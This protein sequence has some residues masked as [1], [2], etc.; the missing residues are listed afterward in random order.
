M[1]LVVGPKILPPS[2]NVLAN[3]NALTAIC[4]NETSSTHI[5][6]KNIINIILVAEGTCCTFKADAVTDRQ[7]RL[8]ISAN[9]SICV[10]SAISYLIMIIK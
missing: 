9:V 5:Q 6:P 10:A 7:F 1:L 8:S 2:R 3:E 4:Q